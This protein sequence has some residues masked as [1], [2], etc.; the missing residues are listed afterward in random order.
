MTALKGDGVDDPDISLV[1]ERIDHRIRDFAA[2]PWTVDG[3]LPQ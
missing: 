3:Y 1:S 2:L